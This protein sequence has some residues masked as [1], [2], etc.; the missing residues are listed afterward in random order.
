MERQG[1]V[2]SSPSPTPC[3]PEYEIVWQGPRRW[4]SLGRGVHT[5]LGGL[6]TSLSCAGSGFL[7]AEV[8]PVHSNFLTSLLCRIQTE[9]IRFGRSTIRGS[10]PSLLNPSSKRKETRSAPHN[11]SGSQILG[12]NRYGSFAGLG[13]SWTGCPRAQGTVYEESNNA[14]GYRLS[15]HPVFY[16]S[17]TGLSYVSLSTVCIFYPQTFLPASP[18]VMNI[19]S[20]SSGPLGLIPQVSAWLWFILP[21]YTV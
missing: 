1:P 8:G 9:P 7:E 4:Q 11:S 6:H 16:S 20:V 19:L 5:I 10:L 17:Y 12:S 18:A 15:A 2:L 21:I 14:L 13:A 3:A